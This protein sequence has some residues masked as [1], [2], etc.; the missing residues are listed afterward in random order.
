[1]EYE[2]HGCLNVR[3]IE[4]RT[5]FIICFN[6]ADKSEKLKVT[7]L[8]FAALALFFGL[9]F[10]TPKTVVVAGS[11]WLARRFRHSSG[12]RPFISFK[13]ASTWT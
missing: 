11:F 10:G 13:E 3:S 8:G 2:S 5:Q 4:R 6:G 12:L 7:W 1:M 9:G